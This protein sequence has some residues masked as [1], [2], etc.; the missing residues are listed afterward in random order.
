MNPTSLSWRDHVQ[1]VNSVLFCV[2]GVILVVRSFLGPVP[3]SV[4]VLGV[5]FVLF[6]AYR[7]SLAIREMWKRAGISK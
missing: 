5:V 1:L 7:L 2:V 3:W 4:T 6:G